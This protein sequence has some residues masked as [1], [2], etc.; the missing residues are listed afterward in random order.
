VPEDLHPGR[1]SVAHG[2][3]P[4]G[5]AWVEVSGHPSRLAD[6]LMGT[7]VPLRID[8]GHPAVR[9]VAIATADGEIQIG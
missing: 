7:D 3:M 8:P 4:V 2:V 9:K 5:I 1:T 6:A